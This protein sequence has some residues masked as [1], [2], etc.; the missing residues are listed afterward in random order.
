M[1]FVHLLGASKADTALLRVG[2]TGTRAFSNEVTF[3]LGDAGEDGHNHLAG[4]R[5]G[6]GPRFGEG[7]KAG[8]GLADGLDDLEQVTSGT[9]QPIE[10]PDSDDISL[11]ELIE[12]SIQLRSVAIGTRDLF[13]EDFAASGLLE[14][15]ELKFRELK[16][17]PPTVERLDRLIRSTMRA[18]KDD[19][20]RRVSEQLSSAP[21]AVLD[22]LL[23]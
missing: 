14:S 11:A 10:L 18:F 20:C 2:T 15:I 16:L 12:H 13:P 4:M 6:V 17:E 7:L 9:R 23:E 1:I 5:G 21:A 8:T 22:R 3:E 19:F